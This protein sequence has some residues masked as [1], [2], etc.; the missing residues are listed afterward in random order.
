M[1]EI[2]NVTPV[3]ELLKNYADTTKFCTPSIPREIREILGS[4]LHNGSIEGSVSCDNPLMFGCLADNTGKYKVAQDLHARAYGAEHALFGVQGSSGN[5]R[6]I[7]KYFSLEGKTHILSTRNIHKSIGIVA[8]EYG[9]DIDFLPINYDQA[10]EL[11]LPNTSEDVRRELER[12]KSMGN[13]V[14]VVLLSNPTYEGLSTNIR[15]IADVI[16]AENKTLPN[17]KQI[18]LFVDEAWGAHLP[19][20]PNNEV[21]PKYS[22]SQGADINTTSIH[23]QGGGLNQTAV[24]HVNDNLI[25]V[26]KLYRVDHEITTTSPSPLLIASIDLARNYLASGKGKEDLEYMTNILSPQLREMVCEIKRISTLDESFLTDYPHLKMD[27][28]KIIINTVNTGLTGDYIASELFNKYKISVEKKE[29]NCVILLLTFELDSKDN[30][31]LAKA[32]QEI[33]K[34]SKVVSQYGHPAF[35]TAIRKFAAPYFVEKMNP[36][37]KE[38]SVIDSSLVD[39]IAAEDITLYPP[40]IPII[41]KGEAFTQEHVDYFLSAR[42]RN[43]TKVAE[44]KSLKTVHVLNEKGEKY[45]HEKQTTCR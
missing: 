14:D 22:L 3:V 6:S 45:V 44:D 5:N 25:D 37:M 15:E 20:L 39:R 30:Y 23:K 35:P 4:M 34:D 7:V 9:L 41:Y 21:L 16:E 31:R 38:A 2:D 18:I 40:G 12:Q 11:F 1:N 33:V 8:S 42:K 29:E 28:T 17:N 10:H 27:L 13:P 26:D 32:L 43:V 24:I 19:F 36:Q